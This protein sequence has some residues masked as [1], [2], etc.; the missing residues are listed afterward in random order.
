[1]LKKLSRLAALFIL[2]LITLPVLSADDNTRSVVSRWNGTFRSSFHGDGRII[3]W[4]LYDDGTF[5]ALLTKD[6]ITAPDRLSG[7]YTLKSGVF[8]FKASCRTPATKHLRTGIEVT[9]GG[10]LEADRWRGYFVLFSAD[11]ASQT[12]YGI[13]EVKTGP[14]AFPL[15]Q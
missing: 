3:N 6:P 2:F 5:T 14:E 1:M 7:R 12:D 11:D 9:G 4:T 8:V 15:N 13:W 10:R